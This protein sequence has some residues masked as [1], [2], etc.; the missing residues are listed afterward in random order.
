V[1]GTIDVRRYINR[2]HTTTLVR[3]INGEFDQRLLDYN[4]RLDVLDARLPKLDLS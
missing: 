1:K 4:K 2:H 3:Q